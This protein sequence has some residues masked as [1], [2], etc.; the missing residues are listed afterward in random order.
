MLDYDN[1]QASQDHITVAHDLKDELSSL[2]CLIP[3]LKNSIHYSKSAKRAISSP[4]KDPLCPFT[5]TAAAAATLALALEAAT[6]P[7]A[8]PELPAALALGALAEA[9]AD[10]DADAT[11]DPF[12]EMLPPSMPP[13]GV[14]FRVARAEAALY[15][16]RVWFVPL[17]L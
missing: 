15:R 8:V 2:L 7:V 10:A 13:S 3:T 9:I 6:V 5:T 11:A 4:V 16:S 12:R 17:G 14:M 1:F